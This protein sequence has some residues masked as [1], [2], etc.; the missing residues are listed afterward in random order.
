MTTS[1]EKIVEALRASLSEN[2]RLRRQNQQLTTA[3]REPVAIV[4]MACRFPGGVESPE[5]LWRLLT[6]GRDAVADFPSDR[7]WDLD[8]LYD[9]DPDHPGTSYTSQG[10]FLYDAAQFDPLLFGISP[11]EA[12]AMDPQQRLLLETSW[13]VFERAGIDPSSLGGTRT[14]VFAG[15]I[16]SGYAIGLPEFP[17]GVQGY[18]GTGTSASVLSGRISYAFGLEGP[19]VTVDTACSSSLVALHLACQALRNGECSLALAGGVTVM[20]VPG[21]FTEFSRQRGLAPDGRCKAFAAAADGTGF[22]EGVGVLLVERL[23]DARRNGHQVLAVVRGSAINQDGASNGLT[24]P[25][26]PSQ[27]RVIRQALANARLSVTDVDAVEA[28]GTGTTLGDPIEAQALLATYGQERAEDQPLWLGSVKSNIGHTQA[29]AGVAGVI[30]MVMALRHEVLPQTLHVDAPSPHID[31]ASGHVSL[32]TEELKWPGTDRP[33]RAGVSSFGISG[34]NAH[35]IL[36][37]APPETPPADDEPERAAG[38]VPWVLSARTRKA[39]QSQAARLLTFTEETPDVSV[40]AVSSAL[41]GTRAALDHRAVVLAS[42]RVEFSRRLHALASGRPAS[43]VTTGSVRSGRLAFMFTGQ[44]SQRLGMGHELYDTEP[45]FAAALEEAFAALDPHLPQ[46]LRDIIFG[47]DPELLQQTQYAQPALFAVETALYRLLTDTY[48]LRPDYL[49]GHSIGE[50]TAAHAAGVLTLPDAARLVTARGHLMQTAPTGGTMIAIQAD[51]DEITEHL[52]PGVDIAALNS[53]SSTVISGDATEAEAIADHFRTLGR[54]TSRLKVSHA[55]HSPHMDPVL[56]DFRQIAAT[57]DYHPARIPVISNTTGQPAENLTSPDYWTQHIRRPV[58]FTD[59]LHHLTHQGVTTFLELG[60]DATLA[61]L[62]DAHA[63]AVLRRNSSEPQALRTALAELWVHGVPV[64]WPHSTDRR[65]DLPTYAFDHQHYWLDAAPGTSATSVRP[66]VPVEA[67]DAPPTLADRFEGLGA[68]ERTSMAEELVRETVAVVLG[69]ADPE[70]VDVSTPF[71]KLGIDSLTAVELRRR[72]GGYTG[73]EIPAVVVFE[74]PTTHDLAEYLVEAMSAPPGATPDGA[75]GAPSGVR[76]TAAVDSLSDLFVRA[77]GQGEF[78]EAHRLALGLAEY[79]PTF[80]GELDGARSPDVVPL[81]RGTASPAVVCFPSFVWKPDFQQYLS[82]AR[83]LTEDRH[84]A[85]SGLPGFRPGEPLPASAEALAR[86]LAAVV[87]RVAGGRRC[88]LLGHSSGGYVAAAV[89][90]QLEEAGEAP[91]GLV[92]V[93]TPWWGSAGGLGSQ[94]WLPVINEML[95]ARGA[96]AGAEDS[97][98]G[99]AWVTARAKY[100]SLDFAIAPRDV[101]TLLL[102]P[103]EPLAGSAADAGWRAEWRPGTTVVEV[104]GNHFS[105]LD[106]AHAQACARAVEGWLATLG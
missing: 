26:G 18:V 6:E 67:A 14:G 37:A 54:K 82:L 83:E 41:L 3:S 66:S 65:V 53:P 74:H 44:G 104:P 56:D 32:L 51:E 15:A 12:L 28:H 73:L 27:Q 29:A 61:M 39:L 102:R 9:P 77:C 95:L 2:E 49:L 78:A 46:P 4:G 105:M 72:L 13:E 90:A 64:A 70:D 100:F 60:P 25:N 84:V 31:W 17:E 47:D 88:V 16:A 36:E 106:S 103:A 10:G 86:A 97:D 62:A 19:A 81:R 7:G 63:T 55:F 94:E 98:A 5:Q 101:R 48:G 92:L 87:R 45:A 79:R 76:A 59:S 69:F 99:D 52:T 68:G 35:V 30:K 42:D 43:G 24:A 89:A 8:S 21:L 58:R 91:A 20:A 22:S 71:I 80:A 23:S 75:S 93:D 38:P 96:A 40:A 57:L 33:R 50:L 85:V 34:T 1:P 11:R